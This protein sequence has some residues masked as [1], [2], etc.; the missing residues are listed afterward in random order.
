[1]IAIVDY[2]MGNLRS[3]QKAC[4]KVG[5]P[6]RLVTTLEE[7]EQ[8]VAVI[9]PGVGAFPAAMHNLKKAGLILALRRVA[10]S[11]RHLL[12]ICLGYQLLF[13]ESEETFGRKDGQAEP[14]LGLIPGRAV[15][16]PEGVKVPQIGWNQLEMAAPTRLFAGIEPG[17][18]VYFVHSYYPEPDDEQV[19]A[20]WTDYGVRFASA[21]SWRNLHGIQFHPEKSSAVGLRILRNFGE[22]VQESL[23]ARVR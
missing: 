7:V 15:R 2:G 5:C 14:G 16:F 23:R 4:E 22:M 10:A 6:A 9:L 18:Y 19:V 8:A 21:V 1:M 3:V 13:E 11:G 17:S 12:G 20:A